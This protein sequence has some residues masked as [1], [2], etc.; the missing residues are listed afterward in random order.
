M[1][2]AIKISTLKN[3]D[4]HGAGMLGPV[5]WSAVGVVRESAGLV[6]NVAELGLALVLDTRKIA[7]SSTPTNTPGKTAPRRLDAH[8]ASNVI[9]FPVPAARRISRWS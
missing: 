7:A 3:S 6:C 1:T 4:R 8:R 9:P 5:I 2:D